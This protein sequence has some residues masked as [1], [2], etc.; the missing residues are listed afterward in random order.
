MTIAERLP[1]AEF[2][3]AS[4]LTWNLALRAIKAQ[5]NGTVLGRTWSLIS[6]L[7][8]IAVYSVIFGIVFASP[9]PVGQNSGVTSFAMWVAVGVVAWTFIS[10]SIGTAMSALVS[11]A[12]L[13]EKVYFPRV[14]LILAA[15]IAT[16][17]TF[18]TDIAVVI[19]V[20]AFV[21]GPEVLLGIPLLIPFILFAAMFGAGVG[22]MLAIAV[23]WF[24]DI[25]HLWG[26][27]SQVWMYASGVVFPLTL[28][29][30]AAASL[31]RSGVTINGDPLPLVFLFRLNPAEQFLE[32]F[33]SIVYGYA[34]PPLEV[35]ISCALWGIGALIVGG[36]IFRAKQA[37]IVEEL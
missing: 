11:N 27:V 23:V 10:G 31:Q 28:V 33:R 5:Y 14:V 19:V 24:R 30:N 13:L 18:A 3:R 16:T 12:G 2:R 9:A 8:T 17:V 26:L 25:E 6:P 34:V 35:W 1:S 21:G 15:V 22:M 29:Q 37:R 36:L 4:A 20:M 7:V 32:A